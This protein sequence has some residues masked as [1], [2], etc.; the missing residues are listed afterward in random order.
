MPLTIRWREAWG[1]TR[2]FA[3]AP[4]CAVRNSADHDDGLSLFVLGCLFLWDIWLLT[5]RGTA[6]WLDHHEAGGV[7]EPDKTLR[8]QLSRDLDAFGVRRA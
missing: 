3:E 5:D 1:E 8:E 6:V 7:L 4:A 2:P